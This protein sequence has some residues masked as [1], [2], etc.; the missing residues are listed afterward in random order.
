MKNYYE[1]LNI[2]EFSDFKEIKKAY[3][4]LAL[5]F[6]PDTNQGDKLAEEK[7]KEI[8]EA[9]ETLRNE[10]KRQTYDRTFKSFFN[11]TDKIEEDIIS[12]VKED[13]KRKSDEEI[14][15][16]RVANIKR[17][18]ELSFEDQAWI[19]VSICLYPGLVGLYMFFKYRRAGYIKKSQTVCK[20]TLISGAFLFILAAFVAIIRSKR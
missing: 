4:K 16:E 6:H 14:E 1:I 5:E 2:A 10:N 3:R 17:H 7:F 20:V 8:Q 12:N 19:A 13:Q 11:K 18:A 15:I 9:Y